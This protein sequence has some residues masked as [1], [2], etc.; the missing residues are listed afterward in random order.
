MGTLRARV[1]QLN[2]AAV[3]AAAVLVILVGI[4]AVLGIIGAELF[5]LFQNALV[6]LSFDSPAVIAGAFAFAVIV[7]LTAGCYYAYHRFVHL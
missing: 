6:A 4:L 5:L 7:G 1:N 2:Q 3:V